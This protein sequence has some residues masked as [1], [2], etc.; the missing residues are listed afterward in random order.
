MNNEKFDE[1]MREH[2]KEC[3]IT[4]VYN[5]LLKI[6]NLDISLLEKEVIFNEIEECCCHMRMQ[7]YQLENKE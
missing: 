3:Y 4:N 1:L 6:Y 7:C 2:N 5:N